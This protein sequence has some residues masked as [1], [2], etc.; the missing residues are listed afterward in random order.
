MKPTAA[1]T[2][3]EYIAEA[4][5]LLRHARTDLAP[6]S[7]DYG[8]LINACIDLTGVME[9][10]RDPRLSPAAT[11]HPVCVVCG[12]PCVGIASTCS[13]A[14]AESVADAVQAPVH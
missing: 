14:C 7:D 3:G 10:I 5:T 1:W 11:V 2:T 8:V 12:R 9:R 4:I 6:A 13:I